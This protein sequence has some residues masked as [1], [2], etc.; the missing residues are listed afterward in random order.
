MSDQT[1]QKFFTAAAQREFARDFLF[2]VTEITLR[3]GAFSFGSDELIY[4]KTAKLPTRKID[5][6][7]V[8]YMGLDFNVP[9]RA[10]YG[11]SGGYNIEFYCDAEA[12][13]HRR[14]LAET[15]E[16]F[17]D[18]TSTGDY[19]IAGPGSVITLH[20]LR[21]D[22]SPIRTYTLVGASIRDCGEM[23]GAISSGS[24]DVVSFTAQFAYHYFREEPGAGIARGI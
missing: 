17:D 3:E 19:N 4:A 24:G 11:E 22:L 20:Q 10:T 21:K 8:P 18:S 23:S 7:P 9:G 13:L 15:R 14:L 1:I 2:R 5:N 6:K 12:E 16:V